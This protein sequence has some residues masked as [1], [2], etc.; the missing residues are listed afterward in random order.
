MPH[1]CIHTLV[2]RL[3][4]EQA[5]LQGQEFIAPLLRNG[6]ARLRLSGLIHTLKITNPS[7][8]WWCCQVLNSRQAAMLSEAQAWQ[9]G[10]YLALWPVL[11][12]LLIEQ[13]RNGDW[14][15]MPF[16][17]SDAFQRFGMRGPQLLHLVES[18]QPFERVIARVEG[19]Q[20]WY[21]EPDR[22][23][24][25][26]IAE[27]LRQALSQEQPQPQVANLSPGEQASY[28]LLTARRLDA[29]ISREE[30]RIRTAL[31]MGGA[32]LLGYERSDNGWRVIWERNG[33][34]SV[35]LVGTD[36]GVISAG[37]CLSGEDERFDLSSI[38]S[39]VTE[40]PDYA[41]WE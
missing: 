10:E 2:S 17:P 5:A 41:R 11:R 7:P 19:R 29:E 33:Q 1:P 22:R 21:D 25:P 6:Q 39:V 30:R 16:N 27:A 37:I 35:S 31:E 13:H 9:R 23:A 4:Q 38:V 15:A 18:G 28:A 14:L 8:G 40:A 34:R 32:R 12:M 36:L 24:D 20:L 3:A 26:S